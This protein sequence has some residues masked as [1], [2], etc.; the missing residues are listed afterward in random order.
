MCAITGDPMACK[1]VGMG[2]TGGIGG[3]GTGGAGG[4]MPRSPYGTS[5]MSAVMRSIVREEGAWALMRGL[6]PRVLFHIPAGAIS[7]YALHSKSYTLYPIPYTL[8][9]ISYTLYPT[10]YT[11]YP[12]PYTLYPLSCILYPIPNTLRL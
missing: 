3:G 1:G 8:Y 5:S 11:L 2:G 9:P 10:P 4:T 12:I 7:W 6:G